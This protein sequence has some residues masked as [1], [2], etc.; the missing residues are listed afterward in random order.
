MGKAT[1]TAWRKG[2]VAARSGKEYADCPYK[3]KHRAWSLRAYRRAW[4]A[5]FERQ[6]EDARLGVIRDILAQS[7]FRF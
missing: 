1:D 3:I 4:M 2:Y 6:K 5:G 7:D